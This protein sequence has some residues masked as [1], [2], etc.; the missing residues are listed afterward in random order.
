MRAA[1][2]PACRRPF[3]F[4]RIGVNGVMDSNRAIPDDERWLGIAVQIADGRPI[5]WNVAARG[6][7][8][9]PHPGSLSLVARLQALERLVHGHQAIRTGT[10]D[11]EEV[12]ETILTETS[13]ARTATALQVQWGPLVIIE[14]IGRG[15]FGDVYRAW[16]P[17]LDRE[18]ALKLIPE[19][20][21]GADTASPVVEEGRLLARVR[22]P[23]VL[24][25]Y[26]AER[27]DG[28]V[29][30]WTELIDG[31]NLAAEVS[32]RGPLEPMEA[33]RI[34]IDVCRALEAV[35]RAGL[36]HRDV[37][38]QNILRDA[39]GRPVLGDFG[40]GIDINEQA[41]VTEPQ[42]AGT[43]LYLAPEV[44]DHQ[45]PSIGSDLYS[46]GV[47]LY[48]LVTADYPVRG[49][50]LAEIRQQHAAGRSVPLGTQRPGVSEEFAAVVDALLTPDAERRYGCATAVAAA[51]ETLSVAATDPA[52]TPRLTMHRRLSLAAAALLATAAAIAGIAAWSARA[53]AVLPLNAG[54]WIVVGEFDNATGD[55]ALDAIPFAVKRELEYSDHVRVAQAS[56]IDDS[57]RLLRRPLDSRLDAGLARQVALQDGGVRAVV[58]GRMHKEGATTVI[59]V[60]IVNPLGG[61]T[62]GRLTERSADVSGITATVRRAAFALR[63]RLGE[64]VESIARSR[65]ALQHTPPP[66]LTAVRSYARG[67]ATAH[68]IS[69]TLPPTG[70]PY[71]GPEWA[72]VER[73]ARDAVEADPTFARAWGLLSDALGA[74]RRGGDNSSAAQMRVAA[75]RAYEEKAFRLIAHA[76]P[77]ERYF[78]ESRL[79]GTRAYQQRTQGKLEG[80][81]R[82]LELSI[83]ATQALLALQPDDDEVS[84][85]A[86]QRLT[87]VL[88]PQFGREITLMRIQA[89]DARPKNVTLNLGVANTHLSEASFDAARRYAARAES[90]IAAAT[91][92]QMNRIRIFG[93]WVAWLQDDAREA[94]RIADRVARTLTGLGEAEHRAVS[95]GL[96]RLYVA[97]GR[98]RIAEEIISAIPA[99]DDPLTAS[100]AWSFAERAKA[101]RFLLTGDSIRLEQ[102]VGTWPDLVPQQRDGPCCGVALQNLIP[103]FIETGRLEGAERN[104]ALFERVATTQGSAGFR[105]LYLDYRG[106]LELARGRPDTA[107]N[108]LKE[109]MAIKRSN[110]PPLSSLPGQYTI[111]ILVR[112]LEKAGHIDEAIA[113]LEE[114]GATR[115]AIAVNGSPATWI[116][117]RADLARLYRTTG[118]SREA[119]AIE[120]HLLKLLAVAD[121]DFA[122]LRELRA[123]QKTQ[124]GT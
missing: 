24:T 95:N 46:V 74:Q 52:V 76:T 66:P 29:G 27:I 61:A 80:E 40:T 36:L 34:G 117:G 65:Q 122:L 91:P 54:D 50:T 63:E 45:P 12:R 32:R 108:L 111:S 53:P 7:S 110:P 30:I 94:L 2:D 58:I 70:L 115:G 11:I 82:E 121:A 93:A 3:E 109:S 86:L 26:G 49:R 124:S 100:D 43:P 44:I 8:G 15:S 18:V 96:A 35:H 48:F 55:E 112:A 84:E 13:R 99:K 123:R 107:V 47:L 116:A 103:F 72:V 19:T 23:N 41:A 1:P 59:D 56:R 87:D 71:Q 10:S 92:G 9:S 114:A 85:S 67:T 98:A 39:G 75:K 89:A 16:D 68:A 4:G 57:L 90:A 120:A 101:D 22:H 78:I 69:S 102:L 97:L 21:S 83:A 33:A 42:I 105:S 88:G 14:K 104:L 5:D 113:V 25:V 28:R 51:L 6:A 79:H 81:R 77:R 20:A 31:E 37:K 60:D 118:R 64:P 62:I 106:A 17:R 119:E 38:A 73:L